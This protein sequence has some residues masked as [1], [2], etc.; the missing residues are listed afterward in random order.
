M[1]TGNNYTDVS[2][3]NSLGADVSELFLLRHAKSSWENPVLSDHERPLNSRGRVAA[4]LMASV[5]SDVNAFPERVLCSTAL[6]ATETVRLLV[7]HWNQPTEIILV[8]DL[9][10]AAPLVIAKVVS[11]WGGSVPNLMVVGHN[12]GFEEFFEEV[13]GTSLAIPTGACLQLNCQLENWSE[14]ALSTRVALVRRWLPKEELAKRADTTGA[15]DSQTP[16]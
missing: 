5:L 2:V 16:D 6:R 15:G 4:A 9:Y 3:R 10:H 14:F 1:L 12:P 13:T 7:T 11:N 8:P